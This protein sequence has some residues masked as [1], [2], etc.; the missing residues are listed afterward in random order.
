MKARPKPCQF[1]PYRRDV[2]SG[3]WHADEYAKLIEY[4]RPTA[5]QPF[6][7]FACHAQPE[8]VCTG[9][10]V[11]GMKQPH[12]KALIALR[13]FPVDGQDDIACDVPLFDTGTQA[14][15]H[16]LS[17]LSAPSGDAQAAI[18]SLNRQIGKRKSTR[19]QG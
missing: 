18:A 6:R 9:W 8:C 3:I 11:V 1:C 19:K 5:E 15:L 16:G 14:A 2:P 10:L 12:D 13:L 7:Q 17:G 4:D